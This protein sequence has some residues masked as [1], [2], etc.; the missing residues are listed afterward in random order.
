MNDIRA[1]KGLIALFLKLSGF[2]GVT[3]PWAIYIMPH[4]MNDIRL[5][6]HEQEHVRQMKYLGVFKFYTLYIWYN[7]KYG[8]QDN[9]FELA[10]RS[11]E[12]SEKELT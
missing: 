4:R 3:L 10:A 12:V 2:T 11:A 7:I 1:A 9:P 6:R 8:Y 5:I